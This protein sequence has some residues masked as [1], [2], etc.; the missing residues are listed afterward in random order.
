MVA[1]RSWNYN[2]LSTAHSINAFSDAGTVDLFSLK[3]FLH[4]ASSTTGSPSF[5]S[6]LFPL[7]IFSKSQPQRSVLGALP[8]H[9][10]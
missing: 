1:T 9:L 5:P 3:C 7:L 6:T 10:Y 4:V 2:W 8:F